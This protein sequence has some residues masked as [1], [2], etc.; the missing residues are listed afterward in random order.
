MVAP[1]SV[2]F[3][4]VVPIWDQRSVVSPQALR[5]FSYLAD[6]FFPTRRIVD[7]LFFPTFPS[8]FFG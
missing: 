1:F 4:P 2:H 3:F 6:V 7:R 8:P 5:D